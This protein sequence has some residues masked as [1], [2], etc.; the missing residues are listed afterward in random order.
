GH[1]LGN[2]ARDGGGCRATAAT[3]LV[4]GVRGY[5]PP[6]RI[7]VCFAAISSSAAFAS[8]WPVSTL[9]RS[10]PRIVSIGAYCG[11]FQKSRAMLN[12]GTSNLA[13]GEELRK[14][15]LCSV[16]MFALPPTPVFTQMFWIAGVWNHF[17]KSRIAA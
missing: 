14:A 3:I 8:I 1:E 16:L 17:T 10:V 12:A 13:K 5:C 11:T 9:F 7:A 2:A 15:A 6:L 4:G